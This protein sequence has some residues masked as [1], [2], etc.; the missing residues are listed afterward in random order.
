MSK[1]GKKHKRDQQPSGSEIIRQCVIYAQSIAAYQAGFE[2][3]LTGNFDHAGSGKGQLG[4]DH[5]RTAD[6]ALARLVAL[7]PAFKGRA[8]LN[9][10]ELF[11]K[12]GVLSVI[13]SQEGGE[14]RSCEATETAYVRF[15]AREVEDSMRAQARDAV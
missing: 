2:M 7:S 5:L 4:R 13:W 6:H 3:D 1:K 8:P 15:F 12:A 10:A 9:E 11:A 14:T